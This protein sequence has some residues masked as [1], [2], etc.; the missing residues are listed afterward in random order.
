MVSKLFFAEC[1][2]SNS[3]LH[4]ATCNLTVLMYYIEE[5]GK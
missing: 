4:I 3:A 1:N 2:L 5:K